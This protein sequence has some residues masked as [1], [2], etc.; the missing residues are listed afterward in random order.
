VFGNKSFNV[1]MVKDSEV[2]PQPEIKLPSQAEVTD[3]AQD[4]ATIA[5]CA[6]AACKAV[7]FFF[8]LSEHVATNIYPGSVK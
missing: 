4:I 5:V 3:F 2:E 7:D 6:Y 8:N 1:K